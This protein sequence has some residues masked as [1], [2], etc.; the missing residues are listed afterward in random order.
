MDMTTFDE[1]D[2]QAAGTD[3]SP[4]TIEYYILG[5]AGEAGE[6]ANEMKK[7]LRDKNGIMDKESRKKI[8]EEAG[9]SLW[10]I[11]RLSKNLSYSLE[12]LALDNLVKLQKRHKK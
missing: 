2:K 7:V 5:L 11:S 9:D 8:L 12:E 3:I 1:Y 10:Y 4:E 6:T